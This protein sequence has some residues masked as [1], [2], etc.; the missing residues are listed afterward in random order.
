[1]R[2]RPDPE[3]SAAERAAGERSLVL[4]ASFASLAGAL[5]GG[6]ILSA[7]ALGAGAGPLAIGVLAAIPFLSQAAQLPA[8]PFIERVRQRRTI[9]V[10]SLTAARVVI[11]LTALLPFLPAAR[12]QLGGLIAAQ[13]AI[14][15]L[16]SFAACAVNSW[17]HQLIGR[18]S[19]GGFFAK[20]LFWG[21]ALACL[22]TLA[23][24]WLLDPHAWIER[25]EAFAIAFAAAGCAGLASSYFLARAPEPQMTAALKPAAMFAALRAPF[26]DSVFAKVLVFMA[27]WNVASNLAAPFLTVYLLQQLNLP[28]ATV[29]SLW[30]TSQVSNALMIY[31]WGKLSDRL[32]NKAILAVALPAYFACMVGLVF[33]DLGD[34]H[35]LRLLLLYAFHLA[36]G[37]ASGGIGLAIGNLGLKLAPQGAGTSYLAVQGLV[38]AAAGGIAPLVAGA[39]AEWFAPRELSVIIRW[40]SPNRTADVVVF[41]F[42]HWEFLFAISALLGL[43]VMHAL[44]NIVE[45]AEISE[46]QVV[47]QLGVEAMRSLDQLSSIAGSIGTLFSPGR[48]LNW[49]P[50]LQ[51]SERRRVPRLQD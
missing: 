23:A 32:S 5:S 18:E 11:L 16:S 21:T 34:H 9:G 40:V 2:L 30:V 20:R 6:V 15:G 51:R 44:S 22:G 42:A 47:Q 38:S 35:A 46:R 3:I 27:A 19:L 24:G 25:R 39:V 13:I 37:A 48:L 10:L 29:T 28:L 33:A 31:L 1:M 49:S 50:R 7:F 8:I 45:G 4:D 36:M 26:L 41:E 12:A 17:L 14:C 43:Y